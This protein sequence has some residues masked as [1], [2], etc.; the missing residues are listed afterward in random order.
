MSAPDQSEKTQAAGE[1][2]VVEALRASLKERER[3]AP[4]EP[5]G[6]T[7]RRER[8]DRDR[9]HELPLSRRGRLARG[10]VGAAA[11]GRRRDRR[12][13]HRPRLG[14]GAAVRP[15]PRQPGHEL[16]PRRRASSTTPASSTPASSGS[17]P[18]EALA[19]DPQQ[20]LLLEAAWEA[21]EDAGHRPADA[22]RQRR[23]ACSP[24]PAP[25]TTALRAARR[26]SRAAL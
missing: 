26:S 20:R 4:G 23:P 8:A 12:L 1:S 19:M 16:R 22:A 2:Q 10:A 3:A 25:R 15:R 13:P 6:C 9:R 17:A 21:L 14:P 24:A 7:P 11:R 18:R 5:S